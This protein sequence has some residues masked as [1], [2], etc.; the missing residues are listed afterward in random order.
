MPGLP[1][2]K[3]ARHQLESS[4]DAGL[5]RK[6]FGTDLM[7]KPEHVAVTQSWFLMKLDR[8]PEGDSG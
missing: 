1:P 2:E 4:E 3:P 7:M 8:F 6:V 5:N